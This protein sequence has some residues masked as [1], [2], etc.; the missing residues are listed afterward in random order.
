MDHI[1]RGRKIVAAYAIIHLIVMAATIIIGLKIGA[2]LQ[3]TVMRAVFQ[4]ILIHSLWKGSRWAQWMH[5][6]SFSVGAVLLVGLCIKWPKLPVLLIGAPMAF[7]FAWLALTFAFSRS[8]RDFLASQRGDLGMAPAYEPAAGSLASG[9]GAAPDQTDWE[10]DETPSVDTSPCRKC[11]IS[12][13]NF[14]LLCP[15]CGTRRE[16]LA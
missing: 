2:P 13:K 1:A 8:I 16:A 12:L 10:E 5:V 9:S 15:D 6:L 4:T 11:G 3:K 7:V 14:V